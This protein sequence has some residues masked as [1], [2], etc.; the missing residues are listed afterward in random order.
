MSDQLV[1]MSVQSVNFYT[2]ARVSN[3]RL[4]SAHARVYTNKMGA[5]AAGDYSA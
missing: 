5:K 1:D 3:K 2:R 4:L